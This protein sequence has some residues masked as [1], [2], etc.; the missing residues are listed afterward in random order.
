MATKVEEI[1]NIALVGHGSSGKTTLADSFLVTVGEASGHH[2]VDDG[3]SICDFDEEEKA[4]K[5][6]IETALTHFK[7]A[8]KQFFILDAP[9][10]PDLIGQA[11]SALR[12][13]DT[14]LICIDAHAGIKV[15]TR[16]M[17]QEAGKAGVGR[18]FLL[19]K[20]DADNIDFPSLVESIREVFGI[21]CVLLNV[22]IGLG[23]DFKGVASTLKIEGNAAGAVIDPS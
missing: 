21:G 19:N 17:F 7:H 23:N 13:A 8:N 1:R 15:N 9:G 6:S 4:H 11:I 5:Y 18:M 12:A 3:T 22:P 16:R 2:S 20:L 10:Y 14:A